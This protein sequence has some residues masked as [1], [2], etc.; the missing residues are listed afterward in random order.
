MGLTRS[1]LHSND[2]VFDGGYCELSFADLFDALMDG[3]AK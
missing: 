1:F 3:D 2:T